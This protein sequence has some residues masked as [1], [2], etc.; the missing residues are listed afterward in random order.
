MRAPQREREGPR[1]FRCASIAR[2]GRWLPAGPPTRT[3][4]HDVSSLRSDVGLGAHVMTRLF[5]L[6]FSV[7]IS[8]LSIGLTHGPTLRHNY[9]AD[10]GAG[11]RVTHAS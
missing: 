9:G 3:P 4:P 1:G 10:P 7:H 5:V 2:E 6:S 8:Y 11:A